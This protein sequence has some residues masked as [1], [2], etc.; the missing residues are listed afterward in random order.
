[1]E[2]ND[3]LEIQLFH[4]LEQV[5]QMNEA[6]RR[7][8]GAYEPNTFMIEQFQEVKNRLTDELRS[9]LSQVTEMRWQAAA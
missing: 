5:K 8:Q 6:I 2:I 3:E 1:M 4:T 9:L 7:H